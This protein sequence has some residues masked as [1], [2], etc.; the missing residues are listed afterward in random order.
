MDFVF[1]LIVKIK[2]NNVEK[3][4]KLINVKLK[5]GKLKIVK[6]PKRKGA[7]NI[8]KYFLFKK[9]IKI[10]PKKIKLFYIKF[11]FLIYSF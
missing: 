11:F 4:K 9:D 8:T 7:N 1:F 3:V 10:C 5:G 6:A 2:N